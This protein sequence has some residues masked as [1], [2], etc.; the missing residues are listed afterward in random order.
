MRPLQVRT[1]GD[2]QL[3]KIVE[4]AALNEGQAV[5]LRQAF[6][7]AIE[8]KDPLQVAMDLSAIDYISS[9]GI[10]FL[11]G[12]KRRIEARLGH[13]VLFGLLPEVLELFTVMKLVSLFEIAEDEARAL[14]L[15]PPSPSN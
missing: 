4:S 1:E 15:F 11:I 5:G 7:A 10:A 13:F 14:E 3:M 12:A 8:V 2:V 9:T 6:N